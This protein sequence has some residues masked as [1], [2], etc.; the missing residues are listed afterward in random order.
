MLFVVVYLFA[1][2]F[3]QWPLIQL[4]QAVHATVQSILL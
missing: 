3:L 4:L 2:L 1:P